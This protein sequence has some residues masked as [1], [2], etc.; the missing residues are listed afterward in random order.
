MSTKDFYNIMF[1]KQPLETTNF[2]K[3][4]N[5]LKAKKPDVISNY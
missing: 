4:L 5:D 2:K 1:N 3:L